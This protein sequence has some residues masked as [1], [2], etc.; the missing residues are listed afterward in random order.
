MAEKSKQE[1]KNK[2]L[3]Q[4]KVKGS[5]K[6]ATIQKHNLVVVDYSATD[7][8][9]VR[10]NQMYQGDDVDSEED[11]RNP[12]NLPVFVETEESKL[13]DDDVK[14]RAFKKLIHQQPDK[15][16]AMSHA[17]TSRVGTWKVYD[18]ATQLGKREPI[19]A[20]ESELKAASDSGDSDSDSDDSS[21]DR[22]RVRH[23][24]SDSDIEQD[25]EQV[26]KIKQESE[27]AYRDKLSKA[28]G[29]DP[30]TNKPGKSGQ[31]DSD[32]EVDDSSESSKGGLSAIRNT[33]QPSKQTARTDE[34][35][36]LLKV[37][38]HLTQLELIKQ[39]EKLAEQFKHAQVVVR[40]ETGAQIDL[41]QS[42]EIE[43]RKLNERNVDELSHLVTPVEER[44]GTI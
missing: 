6:V 29:I 27:Q 37:G 19:N 2:Y 17:A 11:Y 9:R 44:H 30:A 33:E 38:H 23:D 42:K 20:A 15:D 7:A 34:D 5:S 22:P 13:I 12:E 43:L 4:A 3:K 32:I 18:Q 40:D 31:Q 1:L 10:D 41:K 39:R 25:E 24:S 16:D 8:T 28:L 36:Q 21:S 26:V 14:I 35:D